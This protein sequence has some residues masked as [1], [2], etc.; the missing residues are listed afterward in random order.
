MHAE[1]TYS[2]YLRVFRSAQNICGLP[3]YILIHIEYTYYM[4]M[5]TRWQA[6]I[7]TVRH[8]FPSKTVTKGVG[9]GRQVGREGA[10]RRGEKIINAG[11]PLQL[12]I[13]SLFPLLKIAT[14]RGEMKIRMVNNVREE[15]KGDCC[16]HW[17]NYGGSSV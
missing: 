15:G 3:P 9:A 10:G 8:N 1:P 12:L 13:P 5:G 4:P 17:L 6:G 11:V 14:Q 7:Y 16:C 2:L